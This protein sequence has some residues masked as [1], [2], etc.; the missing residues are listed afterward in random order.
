MRIRCPGRSRSLC[1]HYVSVLLFELIGLASLGAWI[2]LLFARGGFWRASVSAVPK[3]DARAKSVV[4]VIPARN[5]ETLVGQ[6]IASL[7]NQDY[8]GSL[9]I[10]LVDDHSTDATIACAGTHERL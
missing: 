6:A 7:L 3:L 5:E 9:H 2:Y 10:I 4:V 8:S 1:H